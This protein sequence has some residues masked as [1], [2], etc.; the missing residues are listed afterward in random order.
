MLHNKLLSLPKTKK[1]IY[2][3][4]S[5][6]RETFFKDILN[7]TNE[8]HSLLDIDKYLH[9]YISSRISA[10][11]EMRF[12]EIASTLTYKELEKKYSSALIMAMTHTILYI[13]AMLNENISQ[14]LVQEEQYKRPYTYS[15][16]TAK[17]IRIEKDPI[18]NFIK[19]ILETKIDGSFY[20][21]API[22][23]FNLERL[24]LS[25]RLSSIYGKEELQP[26]YISPEVC[27]YIMTNSYIKYFLT[28]EISRTSLY[29]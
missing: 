2:S 17:T 23:I 28:K 7:G 29:S 3:I 22:S 16:S 19:T 10:R 25:I 24:T 9:L 20:H 27:A 12:K 6:I 15:S 5:D 1:P 11:S 18:I 13:E 14:H 4:L 21:P 8:T 26:E